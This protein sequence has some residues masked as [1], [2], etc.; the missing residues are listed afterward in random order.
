MHLRFGFDLD[1]VIAE[2]SIPV[3]LLTGAIKDDERRKTISRFLH[4][5][6]F[7]MHP[8]EL[9]HEEDDYIIITGR[10]VEYREITEK[11]LKNHGINAPLFMTD[12]GIARDYPTIDDFFDALALA[13]AQIIKSQSVDVFF[14]D[15]PEV[16]KKLRKLCPTTVIIQVGGRLL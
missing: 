2:V 10:K 8:R 16:V 7:R 12:V 15:S 9:L 13:K 4:Y 6:K 11:W 1:G 5:P 14:E 3:W